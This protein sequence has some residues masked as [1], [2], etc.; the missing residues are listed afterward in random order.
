M[1]VPFLCETGSK[2]ST[3]IHAIQG[4]G[5]TSPM[6]NQVVEVEGIVVGSFQ[7]S[8]QLN[9]FYLQE[10][11]ATWDADAQ[12]SEGVFIFDPARRCP[13]PSAIASA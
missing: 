13:S 7:A 10:P 12:T 6:A 8:S 4:S 5:L 9:G 3:A 2:T 11:D 1:T